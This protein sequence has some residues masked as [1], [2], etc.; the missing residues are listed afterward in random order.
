MNIQ[1][2]EAYRVR[3]LY[4]KF[5]SPSGPQASPGGESGHSPDG[6]HHTVLGSHAGHSYFHSSRH[7][8]MMNCSLHFSQNPLQLISGCTSY[9]SLSI[10][11]VL[12][13]SLVNQ[14]KLPLIANSCRTASYVSLL[15][16]TMTV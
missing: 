7:H 3:K 14:I 8:T 16:M 6:Q 5:S 13:G 9:L 10:I 15:R 11:R 4:R 12:L 2:L 1:I